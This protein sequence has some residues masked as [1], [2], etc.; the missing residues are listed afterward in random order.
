MRGIYVAS[1]SPKAG[2]TMFAC[3]L[4][5]LLQKRGINLGFMKP[6]GSELKR[7]EAGNGDFGALTIQ[8]VLGQTALPAQLTPVIRPNIWADPAI[9]NSR[10]GRHDTLSVIRKAFDAISQERDFM[11]V[12]GT[13]RFPSAGSTYGVDGFSLTEELDL[14]VLLLERF[15]SGLDAGGIDLDAVMFIKKNLGKRLTGIVFNDVPEQDIPALKSLV[16]AYCEKNGIKLFGIIPHDP[17]LTVIRCMDIAYELAGRIV[18][19]NNGASRG[20]S[21]FLIGTMQVESFMSYLRNKPESAVIL[22]GDRA[23]LQLSALYGKCGCLI[24]TGNIG[25]CEM[26]R[27]RADSV[28]TPVIVVREDSYQVARRMSRILKSHKFYNL[29][30]IK[31]GIRLVEEH[32]DIPRLLKRLK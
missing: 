25:P 13:G 5:A 20:V 32:V 27:K 7:V 16:G 19:G 4:G 17:S 24:L 18:A 6:V 30:Q 11:L 14:Q 12:S 29:N 2:K 31:T 28:D 9:R 21:H 3:S 15:E 23:D 22:G 26:V 8:E 1:S 10:S